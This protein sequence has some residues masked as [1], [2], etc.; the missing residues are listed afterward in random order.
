MNAHNRIHTGP[1]LVQETYFVDGKG[2]K[3]HHVISQ[4]SSI[5]LDA[6]ED[7]IEAA[8]HKKKEKPEP[9]HEAKKPGKKG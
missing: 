8:K 9:E 2:W 6:T 5:E 1:E 4:T 3:T 7:E